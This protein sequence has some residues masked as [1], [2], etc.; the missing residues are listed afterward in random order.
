MPFKKQTY[1][2]RGH[3][4]VPENLISVQ[5][6]NGVFRTVCLT[7]RTARLDKIRKTSL[8]KGAH[9]FGSR[10]R[11]SHG[12][13]YTPETM[14]MATKN[15]YSYRACRICSRLRTKANHQKAYY[16]ITNEQRDAKFVAQGSCCEVCGSPEHHGRNWNT[17]HNHRTDKV[18]GILC[19]PCNLTLGM[20]DDSIKRLYLLIKYLEKWKE[21]HEQTA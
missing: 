18:R 6:E 14:F 5:K 3:E 4:L 1:C 12:H 17:D 13:I 9:H 16:G 15:G 19:A 7:C 10:D 21:I 11:C 20:V 2:K 8:P